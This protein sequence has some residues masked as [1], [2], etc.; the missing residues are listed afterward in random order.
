MIVSDALASTA[1]RWISHVHDAWSAA[2]GNG[3]RIV[4]PGRSIGSAIRSC[5]PSSMLP[6]VTTKSARVAPVTQGIVP[7]SR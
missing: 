1:S 2:S 4:T 3:G 7:S 5:R 6:P